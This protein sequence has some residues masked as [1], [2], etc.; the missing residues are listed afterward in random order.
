V[1]PLR[2]PAQLVVEG[3]RVTTDEVLGPATSGPRRTPHSRRQCGCPAG[4]PPATAKPGNPCRPPGAC[5]TG[6]I[7]PARYERRQR[8]RTTHRAWLSLRCLRVATVELHRPGGAARLHRMP[9]E[10]RVP[11]C[12][13]RD[14]RLFRRAP[15]AARAARY[16]LSMSAP[17]FLCPACSRGLSDCVCCDRPFAGPPA[18][19]CDACAGEAAGVSTAWPAAGRNKRGRGSLTSP[20]PAAPL[21]R[22]WPSQGTACQP[23]G[24]SVTRLPGQGRR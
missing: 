23:A 15:T 7:P 2:Q 9:C 16:T 24:H 1:P 12:P 13:R 18:F 3:V 17:A 19:L 11:A 21:A 22:R 10:P 5:R 20:G 14:F 8:R 4:Q 6:N